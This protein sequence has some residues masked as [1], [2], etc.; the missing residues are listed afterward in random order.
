[1]WETPAGSSTI[2]GILFTYP[3]PNLMEHWPRDSITASMKFSIVHLSDLHF[4]ADKNALSYRPLSI[5]GVIGA[6]EPT[7]VAYLILISGDIAYSGKAAEYLHAIAFVNDLK[8]QLET[9]KT[10]PSVYVLCIPGNHDCNFDLAGDT[11]SMAADYLRERIA[12]FKIEGEIAHSCV[13]VHDEYFAFQARLLQNAPKSGAARFAWQEVLELNGHRIVVNCLNSAWLSQ[14]HEKQGELLFPTES[15]FAVWDKFQQCSLAVTMIHHPFNWFPDGNARDLRQSIESFSDIILTGHEHYANAYTKELF[16][17][18]R[19]HYFEGG[20]LQDSSS[21]LPSSFN[22]AV[23]DTEEQTMKAIKVKWQSGMY[24]ESS[25]SKPIPLARRN[26]ISLEHFNL[27]DTFNE[28]L[29]DIGTGFTHTH[30]RKLYLRDL[31]VYPD[32]QRRF[33]GSRAD[34]TNGTNG[35]LSADSIV[36]DLVGGENIAIF[37]DPLSGKTA[38]AKALFEDLRSK[39]LMPLLVSGK[40]VGRISRETVAT[41]LQTIFEQQY[42]S[43][44]WQSYKQLPSKQKIVILDDFHTVQPGV[45][46]PEFLDELSAWFGSVLL[47]S[48]EIAG[49]EMVTEADELGCL[50]PIS[51]FSIREFGNALRGTLIERWVSLEPSQYSSDSGRYQK[52]SALERLISTLLGRNLLPSSPVVVLTLLQAWEASRDQNLAAGSYGYLYETLIMRAVSLIQLHAT[53]IDIV[54]TYLS[55][56]AERMRERDLQTLARIEFNEI[57]LI[58][59]E[60]YGVSVPPNIVDLLIQARVLTSA[61]EGVGFQYRYY[62][63]FFSAMYFRDRMGIENERA[64]IRGVLLQ[65]A[66]TIHY[67]EDAEILLFYV[68]LTKDVETIRGILDCARRVFDDHSACDLDGDIRSV[69]ELYTSTSRPLMLESDNHKKNREE[70]NKALDENDAEFEHRIEKVPRVSLEERDRKSY[71]RT[72]NAV[73][74]MNVA[75]KMLQILGQVLR[76]SPGSLEAGVKREVANEAYLLGLRTLNAVLT[77]TVLDI[78]PFRAFLAELIKE[79]RSVRK[80]S[81]QPSEITRLADESVINFTEGVA[82][83]MIRR[84]SQAVGT[85]HL[86]EIYSGVLSSKPDSVPFRL[87]D[88]SIKVDLF[89]Q[90]PEKELR[91]FKESLSKNPIAVGALRH[92]V[93]LHLYLN[94]VKYRERQQLTAL[95]DIGV[96]HNKLIDNPSKKRR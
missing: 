92:L 75:T 63:F 12:G 39:G 6:V 76:S 40:S 42:R 91:R 47:F 83:G 28:Y 96:N 35:R 2:Q 82:V 67:S 37:G 78:E 60:R 71:D 17:G 11:R 14:L 69:N 53:E 81:I 13:A 59:F 15:V 86:E 51:I 43:T 46:R 87:I 10:K 25:V 19:N 1:M 44:S 65:M 33:A 62:Y 77:V 50:K 49:L 24:T 27:A 89:K 45:Q 72:L 20:V 70:Y 64:R 68:Y 48:D 8:K 29:K 56:V 55:L 23:I 32:L 31:F 94:P 3:G 9:L 90:L 74:R 5:A 36:N 22:V 85:E 66:A 57:Q 61:T 34:R 84:I 95:M 54:K 73:V 79:S 80:E 58:Y 30:R 18:D 38:L 4:K 16:A 21:E 88:L 41:T 52:I 7:C 93:F 26:A